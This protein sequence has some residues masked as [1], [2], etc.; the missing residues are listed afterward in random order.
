MKF[1]KLSKKTAEKLTPYILYAEPPEGNTV[2]CIAIKE[3]GNK[4]VLLKKGDIDGNETLYSADLDYETSDQMMPDEENFDGEIAEFTQSDEKKTSH[5]DD[6]IDAHEKEFAISREIFCSELIRDIDAQCSPKYNRY[7]K[8]ETMKPL[9]GP[10]FISDFHSWESSYNYEH[11]TIL[12]HKINNQG[13][14]QFPDQLKRVRGL[15]TCAVLLVLL[16]KDD[17]FNNN[18]GLVEKG[19]HLQVTLI[20]F[21]RCLSTIMYPNGQETNIENTFSEPLDMVKTIFQQ[22]A[23]ANTNEPPLPASFS[24]AAHI[25]FEIFETIDSLYHMSVASIKKRAEENF[26]LFPLFREAITQDVRRG[27]EHLHRQFKDN[28]E[29]VA[30]QY[31][32]RA[33]KQEGLQV[34][35]SDLDDETITYL[36]SFYNF[37][38]PYET[39]A[40]AE[41][42]LKQLS[43]CFTTQEHNESLQTSPTAQ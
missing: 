23:N 22:Y 17:R 37:A 27:I 25:K 21:G 2:V 29:Y 7:Y 16:G 6:E 36:L 20:D 10:D 18:W 42:F 40:K 26:K 28:P 43:R 3:G 15:G 31:I 1:F 39:S 9:I 33:F 38:K 34:K 5:F 41:A 11:Q 14:I 19:N 13:L 30:A 12:G 35:L 8:A 32:N 4:K 24:Q